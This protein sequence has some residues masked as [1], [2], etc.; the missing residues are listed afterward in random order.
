MGNEARVGPGSRPRR[1]EASRAPGA[2][3]APPGHAQT[4]GASMRAGS[5]ALAVGKASTGKREFTGRLQVTGK[6]DKLM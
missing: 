3:R 4:W 6:D 2:L 5:C 1:A